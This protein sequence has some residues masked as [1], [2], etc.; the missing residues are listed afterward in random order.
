MDNLPDELANLVK[1]KT[2]N[3]AFNA[4]TVIDN[5]VIRNFTQL[6]DLNA[7]NNLLDHL[8]RGFSHSRVSASSTSPTTSS[9]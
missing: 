6:E 7:S 2:L 3:L 9:R 4:L 1:L 8:P 5:V